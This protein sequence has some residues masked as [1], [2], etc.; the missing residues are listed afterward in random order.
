V[1]QCTLTAV[2]FPEVMFGD[3]EAANAI[4]PNSSPIAPKEKWSNGV[5]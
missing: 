1:A 3:L 2:A 4:A 5:F